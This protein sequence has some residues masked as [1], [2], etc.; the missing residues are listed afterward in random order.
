M[1]AYS[2]VYLEFYWNTSLRNMFDYPT[3]LSLDVDYFSESRSHFKR[4][5]A[6]IWQQIVKELTDEMIKWFDE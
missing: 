5:Y 2:N 3:K 1:A 6:E 4:M